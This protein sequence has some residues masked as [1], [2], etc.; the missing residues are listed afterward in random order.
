MVRIKIRDEDEYQLP[1]DIHYLNNAYMSLL[2][3]SV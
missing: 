1:E 3:K 2:L